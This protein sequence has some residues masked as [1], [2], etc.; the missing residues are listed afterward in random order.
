MHCV[1]F[2]VNLYACMNFVM[3]SAWL[4]Y[5]FSKHVQCT[6]MATL[7][8][9]VIGDDIMFLGKGLLWLNGLR[10]HTFTVSECVTGP[11]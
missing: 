1:N 8:Y 6:P 7:L 5:P 4:S 2:C 3:Q 9:L 11:M 10:Y